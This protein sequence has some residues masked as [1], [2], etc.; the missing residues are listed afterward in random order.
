MNKL[1]VLKQYFGYT[2]FRGGQEQLIDAILSGRDA[3][4]I[5]PTGGGK[6]LCYQIPAL[7]FGGVSF[8]ISPLISLM[9]DQVMALKAIGVPAA[10]IN[11]SLSYEQQQTVYDNLRAGAYKIVYVAPERLAVEEFV[12]LCLRLP[13]SFVAVDEAHC[14]SQ[15]GQ[16]FRPSYLRIV[17]FLETLPRRPVLA[18][19]TATATK[20]VREDIEQALRLRSPLRVVTGFD[21]PNLNFEVLQPGDKTAALVKLITER[22]DKSGIVYCATRNNV[23]RVCTLLQEKG[24]PATRYHAGLSAGERQ[25]NQEDFIYD[26]APIMVATTAFGMGINKS[27]VNYVI[28]Y[29][30]PMSLEEYYQEAGRAGRD[31]E[32]ADCILLFSMSDVATAAHMIGPSGENPDLTDTDRNQLMIKDRAL[33]NQMIDYCKTTGCLRGHILDY[34]GQPHEERCENCGN[35]RTV[36][37]SKDITREAQMILSCIIRIHKKLGYGL[38]KSMLINV[39][40]GSKMDKIMSLGLDKLPTYG[41]LSEVPRVQTRD[42]VEF[43]EDRGYLFVDPQFASVQV[44]KTAGKVLFEGE[45]VEMSFKE[46]PPSKTKSKSQRKGKSKS[47]S[48]VTHN[49]KGLYDVLRNLRAE[50]AHHENVPVYIIFSNASLTDMAAKHPK[51]I[52]EFLTVLGVGQ[53][54]AARYG[55]VFLK[56]IADFDGV[57]FKPQAESSATTTPPALKGKSLYDAL[58]ALRLE[59]AQKEN[60]PAYVIFPNDSLQEMADKRP[61]TIDELLTIKGVGPTKAERYGEIF[62]KAIADF[63]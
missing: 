6:S 30:M 49:S 33:L 29:N 31:G 45:K 44:T 9:K 28:H 18:A 38:G 26:R 11:S 47:E 13:I 15:W 41:L 39:L 14:I 4:G 21:R 22:E 12:S 24:F 60:V 25:H 59:L 48:A 10:F 53:V 51:N 17:D 27:N 58:R 56:A 19:F 54:K 46:L 55:D 62:V 63:E 8:V 61:K 7:M 3:L 42:M 16:D 52:D 32:P 35:C 36:F 34:F 23:E 40:Q 20:K 1:D 37:K 5:M 50:L 2:S 43:L 57:E